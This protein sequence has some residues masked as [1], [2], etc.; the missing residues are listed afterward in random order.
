M[1]LEGLQRVLVVGGDEDHVRHDLALERSQHAEPVHAGHLHVEEDQVGVLV[2]NGIDGLLA[3]AVLADDGDVV[4][5]PEHHPDA[6]TR[7]G[8]VV[9][10]EGAQGHAET[11]STDAAS[12]AASP[13]GRR[14]RTTA[15]PSGWLESVSTAPGPYNSRRRSRVL[16]KPM[17][18]MGSPSGP[19]LKPGPSS[20]TARSSQ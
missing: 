11:P 2:A 9:D 12:S 4:M 14:S 5:H 20:R 16:R 13:I 1:H 7:E 10:D 15:P 6:L 18:L 8:L 3:I 19:S 17:P